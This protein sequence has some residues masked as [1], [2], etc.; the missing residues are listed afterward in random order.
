MPSGSIGARAERS[1]QT[2]AARPSTPTARVGEHQRRAE[3]ELLPGDQRVGQRPE[4]DRAQRGTEQV[5]RVRGLR[6]AAL[7]HVPD[8]RSTTTATASGRLM[9]KT[10][11]QPDG[12]HQPAAE[13]RAG[14]AGDA[15]Q[16]RPGADRAHPVL[17]PEG[18][19]QDRQAARRQ[20]RAADALDRA[21]GD[22]R[23][24]VRRDPAGQRRHGEPHDAD[25]EDPAPAEAVAQRAAE[26]DQRGQGQR[27]GVDRPLQPGHAGVQRLADGRAARR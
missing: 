8:R 23:P 4:A 17:R 3:P 6:V 7:G 1:R 15:G 16:T 20:Q 21:G 13:E 12:L 9:R 26:Q 11:R 2:N 27:V 18:R 14:R 24:D 10:H 25:D 19:L 5:E 22:Q